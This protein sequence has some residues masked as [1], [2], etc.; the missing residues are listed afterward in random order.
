MQNSTPRVRTTT[1]AAS[2]RTT[3]SDYGRWFTV[4]SVTGAAT[5]NVGV[6]EDV[7]QPM[8]AGICFG[9]PQDTAYFRRIVLHNPGVAPITV[10]HAISEEPINESQAAVFA[11]MA[12]SLSNI[13]QE[14]NGAVGAQVADLVL[15]VT[16]GPATLIRAANTSRTEIEITAPVTNGAGLVYLGIT[17]A[18]A[19]AVDKFIILAAG[20]VWWSERE[21]GAV[22]GCGST[23]AEIVNAREA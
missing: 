6:G 14:L 17:A 18:R 20:D 15:A 8:P 16:P 1:I 7:P 22:Y 3:V 5:V 9:L 4:L 21:K 2:S 10:V 12:A 13:E 11:A 19:T 23:G